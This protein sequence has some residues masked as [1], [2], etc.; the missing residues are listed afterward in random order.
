[1]PSHK[2]YTSTSCNVNTTYYYNE[3][4][5]YTLIYIYIYYFIKG[6]HA[7]SIRYALSYTFNKQRETLKTR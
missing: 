4:V 1:M 3:Y 6:R 7:Y 5:I 2:I